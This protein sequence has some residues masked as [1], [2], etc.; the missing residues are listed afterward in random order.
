MNYISFYGALFS[1][2]GPT[3]AIIQHCGK[4][5]N[6]VEGKGNVLTF[7]SVYSLGVKQYLRSVPRFNFTRYLIILRIFIFSKM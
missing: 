1:V 7:K 2:G 5:L 3:K 6:R 4:I